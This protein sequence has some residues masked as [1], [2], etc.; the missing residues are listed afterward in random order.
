MRSTVCFLFWAK[1]NLR[2]RQWSR[3]TKT[4]SQI[5]FLFFPIKL[6]YFF[7]FKKGFWSE[8][9]RSRESSLFSFKAFSSLNAVACSKWNHCG[10]FHSRSKKYLSLFSAVCHIT[11]NVDRTSSFNVAFKLER[12]HQFTA[13]LE[14]GK[15]KITVKL[16]HERPFVFHTQVLLEKRSGDKSQNRGE[17]SKRPW[18][19]H[20]QILQGQNGR[21]HRRGG[22]AHHGVIVR[23]R[24][25]TLEAGV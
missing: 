6:T 9:E 1:T 4:I 17:Q 10:L 25:V 19:C 3:I 11:V 8:L 16:I 12:N 18:G 15:K 22:V 24:A 21:L 2:M 5:Q 13:F 7:F 23:R 20:S 14:V